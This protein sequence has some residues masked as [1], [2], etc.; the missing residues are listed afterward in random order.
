MPASPFADD[1]AIY[2]GGYDASEAPARDTARI[3]H[4]TVAAAPGAVH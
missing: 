4:A 3:V 2:F 1:A